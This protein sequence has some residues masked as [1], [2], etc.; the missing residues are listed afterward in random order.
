M[1]DRADTTKICVICIA[2]LFCASEACW[3]TGEKPQCRNALQTREHHTCVTTARAKHW[4][5]GIGCTSQGFYRKSDGCILHYRHQ[6]IWLPVICCQSLPFL[7]TSVWSTWGK[8]AQ[9]Q[10]CAMGLA[11]K[12]R[13]VAG[14]TLNLFQA[15]FHYTR[16]LKSSRY[17]QSTKIPHNNFGPY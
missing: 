4:C 9:A 2:F 17:V 3:H 12:Y 5:S 14:A 15:L 11:H 7:S 1:A 6:G 16:W 8:L 13:N 10:T